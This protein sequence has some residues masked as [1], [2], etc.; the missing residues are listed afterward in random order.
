MQADFVTGTS[1]INDLSSAKYNDGDRLIEAQWAETV[2]ND[3]EGEETNRSANTDCTVTVDSSVSIDFSNN[4]ASV[5][6]TV[7]NC[8][9]NNQDLMLVSYESPCNNA[10]G[11]GGKWDPSNADQQEVFDT[12]KQ[13]GVGNVTNTI[14]VDVPP[15]TAGAPQRSNAEAYY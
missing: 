4:T 13:S 9:G 11:S 2:N 7:T 12:N 6:Y 10:A 5:T 8:G 15:L 3:T 1:Q 14:T